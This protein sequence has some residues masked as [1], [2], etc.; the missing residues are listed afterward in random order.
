M[1]KFKNI[2]AR[3]PLVGVCA[4]LFS[5]I[6]LSG[7]INDEPAVKSLE[8]GD[9]LPQFSVE[10]SDGSVVSTASMKGKNG[11][12]VFFNTA[13]PD[14]RKELPEVQKV[15]EIFQ[16]NPSVVIAAIAREEGEAEIRKY[17]EANSLTIPFSP[18]ENREV[19][20]LFAT[21]VIPRIYICDPSG[22]IIFTSGDVDMPNAET[23]TQWLLKK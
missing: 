8:V 17:W 12:I 13:C 2:N 1:K 22:K 4:F 23:L 7:C 16:D 11:M 18:Q 14:C 21:S 20:S 9:A 19:Y 3:I 15:W 10:M 6:F 5:A